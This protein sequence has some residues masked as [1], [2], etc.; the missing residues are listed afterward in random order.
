MQIPGTLLL[1]HL[2]TAQNGEEMA[3]TKDDIRRWLNEGVRQK[4]THV[5]VVCDTFSHEDY[6]VYVKPTEN[7]RERAENLGSMQSL[8]EVYN[9][10]LDLETQ[11]QAR[12]V[13]NY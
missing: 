8:M 10:A 11:I 3:T 5:I 1:D 7:V 13:Y 2:G 6:P 4:A 9:L 12:R